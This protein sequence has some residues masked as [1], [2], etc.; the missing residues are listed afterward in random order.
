MEAMH[1]F[2]LNESTKKNLTI[3]SI[4]FGIIIGMTALLIIMTLLSRNSWKNGL[5]QEVQNVLDSYQPSTYTVAKSLQ[6]DSTF[7]T[8]SA[9][10]SLMKKGGQK[11]QGHYGIIVRM[12]SILGPLP[13]VFVYDE[14][15]SVFFAG[16]AVDNGKASSTVD[17]HV[18][19]TI[20]KYWEDMIPKIIAKTR[21]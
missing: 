5:A 4:F 1:R 16:Y 21:K 14:G 19:S 3:F 10:F 13:G 12:P 17:R 8:S 11:K 2:S 20:I 9:V 15:G 7:A 18:S 6:L